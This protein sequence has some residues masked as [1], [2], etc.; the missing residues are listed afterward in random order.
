MCARATLFWAYFSF[1]RGKYAGKA[2]WL[3]MK[4]FFR[5]FSDFGL[6][7][8]GFGC[9]LYDV[10]LEKGRCSPQNRICDESFVWHAGR[11]GSKKIRKIFG[12]RF[13][14]A[15]KCAIVNITV[16][17][18]RRFGW[19]GVILESSGNRDSVVSVE[20]KCSSQ[21]GPGIFRNFLKRALT[22]RKSMLY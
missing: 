9:I 13:D 3:R 14:K 10:G 5:F 21:R 20:W 8:G 4:H 7:R 1:F 19:C 15:Q 22:K 2:I 6:T 16:W 12:K 11:A 17:F 18:G